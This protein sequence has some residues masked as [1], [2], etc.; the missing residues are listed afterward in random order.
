MILTC[1]TANDKIGRKLI[2]LQIPATNTS[3]GAVVEAVIVGNA[4]RP[5][6]FAGLLGTLNMSFA[7][8]GLAALLI[9][10]VGYRGLPDSFIQEQA[11]FMP[12]P[13]H[14]MVIASMIIL[15]LM[16]FAGFQL[17]QDRPGARVLCRI[18][19]VAEIAYFAVFWYRWPLGISPLHW[20]MVAS[21]LLNAGLYLQIVTA[22]P[23][24][25]LILLGIP[26]RS[27]RRVTA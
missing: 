15:P 20:S 6:R 24:V 19:F 9:Q 18:L 2:Y 16:A 25:G 4:A 1:V 3:M 5:E 13:F 10:M 11:P 17:R 21:G 12:R 26:R 7:G 8:L 27:L 14:E 22:Y 23:I